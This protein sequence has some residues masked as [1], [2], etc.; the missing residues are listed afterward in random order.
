MPRSR[1]STIAASMSP[2]VSCKARLQSIIPAPVRSR[3]SL[4]SVAEISAIRVFLRR[5]NSVFRLRG[6]FVLRVAPGGHRHRFA[7][8]DGLDR[9]ARLH[10]L[11]VALG[12]GRRRGAVAVALTL[13]VA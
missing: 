10:D 1:S 8:R 12:R 13:E 6:A 2:F 5:R 9:G 7:L 4:T 3:S 11:R